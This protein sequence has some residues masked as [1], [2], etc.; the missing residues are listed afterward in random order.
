MP[1]LR[2]RERALQSE[3]QSILDQVKE[4]AWRIWT[5]G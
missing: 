1:E 2:Q 3:L 4:V 5:T